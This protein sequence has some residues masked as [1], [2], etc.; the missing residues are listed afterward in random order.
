MSK[1]TSIRK[2]KGTLA[3]ALCAGLLT[4][5]ADLARTGSGP[6]FLIMESLT[7]TAGGEGTAASFLL[8]DV[9]S[10]TDVTVGGVTTQTAGVI[11]DTGQ[12]VIRAEMKNQ[13]S[14]T[15]PS[16]LNSIT[17]SRYHI[18]YTRSDGRNQQGVDVPYAF[19]GA[20]TLTIPIGTSGSI[21]FDWV[22]HQAKLEAPLITMRDS[23]GGTRGGLLFL[24]V[25]AEITF[26]GADQAGNEVSVS[27]LMNIRFSDF[28]D[29]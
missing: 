11:N 20:A 7:G 26:Y 27:G 2:L 19:D 16:A 3:A 1:T 25:I 9:V 28:A 21:A 13:L 24:D 17:I 12:A 6:S 22:R 5:C 10:T 29:E 4:S 14:P 18:R 15:A 8:S 23:S